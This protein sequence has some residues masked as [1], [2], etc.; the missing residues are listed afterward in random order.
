MKVG[1]GHQDTESV[2]NSDDEGPAQARALASRAS[3]G[4]RTHVAG[5][6]ARVL[7]SAGAGARGCGCFLA[8]CWGRGRGGAGARGRALPGCCARCRAWAVCVRAQA[9]KTSFG[10][11]EVH[12]GQCLSSPG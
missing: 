3:R 12:A 1:R 4:A 7:A 11:G 8:G 5:A 2:T 10:Q 6:R 9:R